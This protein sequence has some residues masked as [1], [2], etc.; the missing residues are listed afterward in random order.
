VETEPM[1]KFQKERLLIAS[2][3]VL[4]LIIFVITTA[5]FGE[6]APGLAAVFIISSIAISIVLAYRIQS[7]LINPLEARVSGL[8]QKTRA[9]LSTEELR[10]LFPAL[11]TYISHLEQEF[12][13]GKEKLNDEIG[14]L[15]G[16]YAGLRRHNSEILKSLE[17]VDQDTSKTNLEEKVL[18]ELCLSE[19]K[20]II[21]FTNRI[22]DKGA[23]TNKADFNNCINEITQAVRSLEFLVQESASITPSGEK[24]EVD[25]WQIADDTLALLDPIINRLQCNV[26]VKINKNCPTTLNVRSGTLRS[27]LFHY[28]LHYFLHNQ[29]LHNQFL[30]NQF[31]HNQS[32]SG[33]EQNLT[34]EISFSPESEFIFAMD[35][36]N[37]PD[38][39]KASK[40]LLELASQDVS[41]EGGLLSLSAG[42]DTTLQNPSGQGLTGI[43]ICDTI[44]QRES[45]YSRL[46][47]LGVQIVDDFKAA[48]L[49]FCIVDDETGEAFRAVQQYLKPDINILL[50]NNKTL[51]ERKYWHQLRHPVNQYELKQ[52][53]TLIKPVNQASEIY[54]ILIVDDNEAN[55]RL[56]ELQLIELGHNVSAATEGHQAV[57][58]CSEH[59]FDLVFL[60]ILMPGMDG[61]E[62][63]RLIHELEVIVPPI[64]GLTAHVT[65]EERQSYLAAGMSEVIVK[66]IRM[67]KLKS[68]LHRQINFPGAKPALPAARI[69]ALSLFDFDLSLSVARERPELAAEFLQILI[70]NLPA[71]LEQINNAF[72]GHDGTALK[73]SVHKLNG[74]VKYCGVPRLANAIDKLES[75]VKTSGEEHARSTLNLLNSETN[76][77]LKWYG[78]NPEPFGK[79]TGSVE[80]T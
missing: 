69:Q 26:F 78:E 6:P 34:L 57:N 48:K 56:L 77:L 18:R 54:E 17:S 29:F 66:P 65:N 31:L 14:T 73:A 5:I 46:T 36:K 20:T 61:I 68:V 15:K 13:V 32:L 79:Q 27:V 50:L 1:N 75:I 35:V 9:G 33:Q 52:L 21:G 19:L 49:D 8:Y 72:K 74:A 80:S 2:L 70:L 62:T 22:N 67:E 30:H 51:Y 76:S 40:R 63:T 53:L 24:Y 59:Q 23:N 10:E 37:Y 12:E 25:P 43:I 44:L 58:L 64:V 38:L 42:S 4:V 11:E 47:Q 28:L 7:N 71:D 45:L 39:S 41:F 16:K 55:L 60:D 3:P